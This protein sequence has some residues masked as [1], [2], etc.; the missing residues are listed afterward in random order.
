MAQS[1][2][3]ARGRTAKMDGNAHTLTALKRWSIGHDTPLPEINKI[4]EIHI[5]DF[6]NTRAYSSLSAC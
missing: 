4:S 5:Y 6:D 3:Q 1:Q 2:S